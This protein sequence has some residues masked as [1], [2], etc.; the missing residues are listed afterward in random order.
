MKKVYYGGCR[1]CD[2]CGGCFQRKYGEAW[3]DWSQ[4][5]FCKVEHFRAWNRGANHHNYRTGLRKRKDGYIR[6]SDDQY[7]HRYKMEE[8]LGRKLDSKEH[9]HHIDHDPSNN[10]IKNL[11]LVSAN[12]HGFEH[13]KQ[14]ERS[15][16]GRFI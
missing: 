7:E 13:S 14:R 2:F 10:N 15:E 8:Y 4:R 16:L 3:R 11:R 12:E 6:L 9:V 5:R 1:K